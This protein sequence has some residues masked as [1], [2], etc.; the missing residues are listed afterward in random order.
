MGDPLAVNFEI[1]SPGEQE[2]LA[3]RGKNPSSIKNMMLDE[4]ARIEREW[5]LV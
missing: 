1:D 3:A 5:D 4:I 2:R